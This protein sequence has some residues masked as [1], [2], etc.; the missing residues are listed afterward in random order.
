MARHPAFPGHLRYTRHPTF[1]G[2]PQH[3]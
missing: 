3:S 2:H 1:P